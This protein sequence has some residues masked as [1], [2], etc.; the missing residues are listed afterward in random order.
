MELWIEGV[1]QDAVLAGNGGNYLCHE[2]FDRS[3]ACHEALCKDESSIEFA[4]V[5]S[6]SARCFYA[7]FALEG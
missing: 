4:A 7:H 1:N 5:L 2:S 3:G 6:L